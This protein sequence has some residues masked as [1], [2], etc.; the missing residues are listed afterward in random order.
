MKQTQKRTWAEIDLG[1]LEH[2]YHALRT[3]PPR[4]CKFLG[5]VKANAYGHGAIPVARRLEKL[6]T[7]YLAVACLDEGAEL[8][9][10]GITAPILV[11]GHTPVEF[12]ADL[13]RLRLTQTVYHLE[14]AKALSAAAQAEGRPLKIHLKA[15][16]GMSRLGLLSDEAH[17]DAAA[18]E[19]AA[20]CALPGLEAEGIYTHFS[21]ADGSEA[22]T[23]CQ[24]RRFTAVIDAL[25][26]KGI[27]FPLRHCA[28]SA[29]TLRFPCS[30]LNMVRPGIALYGYLPAPSCGGQ[31]AGE[32]RPV[33]TLK[34]RVAEVKELPAGAPVSYGRTAILEKD[35]RMAVLSIGYADGFARALSNRGTVLLGGEE[36]PVTGRVCMD[37][38]M[39]PAGETVQVGDV[40]EVF[41][42][43]LPLER[44]AA[45][46]DTIPYEILCNVS[47]RVPRVYVE[48]A[49]R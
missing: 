9:V 30:H 35:T 26:A 18:E 10:A 37:L 15:D 14:T 48:P 1:A 36:R 39:V 22:F 46:L 11:L 44:M 25:S 31:L 8:R 42:P 21:D 19:L 32:L 6:G 16:T 5:V 47:R 41:G 33:M 20:I 17:I 24:L 45:L 2:N 29:G 38:C 13:V 4:N 43:N 23:M 34:T 3:L 40:A 27:S 7:D 49:G 28:A 12:A